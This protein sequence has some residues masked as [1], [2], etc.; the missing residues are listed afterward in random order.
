MEARE[1]AVAE[2]YLDLLKGCLTRELLTE[3][4]QALSTRQTAIWKGLA[5]RLPKQLLARRDLELVR[6]T[7]HDPDIRHEGRDWPLSA[8]TMIG[9]RRLDNL[10]YCVTEALVSEVPGDLI[11][12]GV[13]RGGASI[14][15]RAVL[16]AHGDI[17]RRVWLADSFCGLPPPDAARY[18]ADSGDALWKCDEL[19]IP[20]EEVKSNFARYGLLDDQV[21]FLVGWFDDTLPTAP[22]DRLCVLRLD[23][24]LYQST[25]VALTALYPKLSIGGFVI[26][27]DFGA[28]PACRSAVEDY[29]SQHRISEEIIPVDWTGAFWRRQG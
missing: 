5:Y 20:V 1:A 14:F 26:I 11:E 9:R 29:R 28:M 10:Q 27:D 3:R 12:T 21:G 17:T 8:E 22:I 25:M 7:Q 4:Y 23:G 13:W 16:K 24:D 2:L 15:M 18:P 19:A 6:R